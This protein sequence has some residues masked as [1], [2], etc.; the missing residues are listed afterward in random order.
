MSSETPKYKITSDD[1]QSKA[2]DNTVSHI[3]KAKEMVLVREVGENTASRDGLLTIGIF[4]AAG[5]ASGFIIWLLWQ[6]LPQYD[7]D[8]QAGN[9]QASVTIAVTIAC[10]L[11][12]ADGA[13]SRSPAK[14]L[15]TFGIALGAALFLSFLL[16][17]LANYLYSS[18]TEALLQAIYDEGFDPSTE[19]FWSEVSSRNHLNRGIAWALLGLAAG[20]STGISSLAVKRALITSAGGLFGGFMGGFLFD[21]FQGEA[22]AQIT[23]LVVTGGFVGLSVSVLEQATKANWLE[24]VKGGMAG[25]QFILY[26]DE[27][28][29][30]S[31]P[32]ANI[33]LIKDPS[34]PPIALLIKRSGK[35]STLHT[36]LPGIPAVVDGVSGMQL[37]L[38]EG[39]LIAVG[40]TEIRFRERAKQVNN[41]APVRR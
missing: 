16:G 19:I 18:S 6:I 22:A 26:Q 21:Y 41:S 34:I 28:T 15:R 39:S 1:L 3:I 24:I 20:A 38:K 30:G 4:T 23:G 25:K 33:T 5:L 17:L 36:A 32:N 27:I 2:V 14:M 12:I 13:L 40:N 8:A 37:P 11:A 10:L 29:I 7:N 9:M 35:V 31:S